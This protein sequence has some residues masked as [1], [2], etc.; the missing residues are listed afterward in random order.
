MNLGLKLNNKVADF[1]SAVHHK[2]L[3]LKR[4]VYYSNRIGSQPNANPK[5]KYHFFM[6]DIAYKHFLKLKLEKI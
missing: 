5:L 4:R 3:R 2:S 6:P 1:D